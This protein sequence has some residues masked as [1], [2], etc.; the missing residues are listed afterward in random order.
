VDN[1]MPTIFYLIIAHGYDIP[2]QR[3]PPILTQVIIT[4]HYVNQV[5]S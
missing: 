5:S 2:G 3:A 1:G 4:L